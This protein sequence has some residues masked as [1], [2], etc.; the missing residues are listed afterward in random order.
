M[1]PEHLPWRIA[2]AL[3]GGLAFPVLKLTG[4]MD[5]PWFPDLI[6]LSLLL[7]LGVLGITFLGLGGG[8]RD[9]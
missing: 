6:A 5:L 9:G 1:S 2:V 8:W 7:M 4:R 3:F